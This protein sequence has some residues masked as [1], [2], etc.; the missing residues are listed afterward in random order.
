MVKIMQQEQEVYEI[1]IKRFYV[2][3]YI[4]TEC[5]MCGLLTDNEGEYLSYPSVGKPFKVLFSC[6]ECD[7]EWYHEILL[8]LNIEI[9][10]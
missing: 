6:D 3:W 2:P 8:K 7:H 10:K 9:V 5:P 1:D 4:E